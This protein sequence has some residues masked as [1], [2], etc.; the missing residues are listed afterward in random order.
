MQ[1]K[2]LGKIFDP[3]EHK[4]FNGCKEFAQSPQ[5]LILEDLVRIYFSTRYLDT[6]GKH[7]SHI[8]FV[9]FTYDLQ[10]I[11]HVADH[12]VIALGKKGCFDEHGIFPL[13]VIRH[14][15][16]VYGY[17][18]GWNRRVSVPVDGAIGF[19]VSYDEGKTFAR[20]GDGPILAPTYNEPFLVADPFV[21]I[22]NNKF[23]MWYIFGSGWITGKNS[24]QPE[25]VY[26]IAQATSDDG[27]SWKRNGIFIIPGS[28][29]EECQALPTVIKI[30]DMYHMYFCYRHTFDFRQN[31]ERGYR[32]GYAFSKDLIDWTRDDSASGITIS[33]NGWDS[34][35]MCYPHIFKVGGKVFLLYNGNQFGKYGFGVAELQN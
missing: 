30:D 11:M 8:S 34:E 4:L 29:E 35:M 14:Q 25:K 18:G 31:A 1:W 12:E 22:Y 23:Y 15:D 26:K 3:S 33:E 2:K 9:D 16:K 24:H 5:V 32:L 27:M 13:N 20:S 6:T 21:Q 19:A 17:I 28:F 10:N 7:L